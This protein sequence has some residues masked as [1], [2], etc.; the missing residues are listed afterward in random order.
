MNLVIGDVIA[1]RSQNAETGKTDEFR[2]VVLE[3]YV[4]GICVVSREDG[5][6]IRWAADESNTRILRPTERRWK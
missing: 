2:G 3:S 6:E 1:M 5:E 4:E